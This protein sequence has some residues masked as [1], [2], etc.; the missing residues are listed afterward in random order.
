MIRIIVIGLIIYLLI[1]I[2]KRWA[3]NK[4]TASSTQKSHSENHPKNMVQCSVCQL[5]I[6]ENEALQKEGE[7]YC[8]QAHLDEK[9]D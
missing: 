8:S 5:H 4:N 2:F 6:P 3:A 1:R 9:Q 7:F